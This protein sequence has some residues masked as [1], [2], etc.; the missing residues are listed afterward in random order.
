MEVCDTIGLETISKRQWF[1]IQK[2]IVSGDS[3]YD[4]PGH[5]ASYGTYSLLDIKLNLK[6]SY[7]LEVEGLERSLSHL[8]EYD[9]T[10]SKAMRLEY[11]S[12]QHE[13]DLWHIVKSGGVTK[14]KEKWISVLHHITNVH[15]CI[16]GETMAK[17]QHPTYTPEEES[18]CPWLLPNCA[19][20]QHLQK[21]VLG[22]QLLKKLEKTTLG[23]HTG[24]LESLHS[25]YTKYAT[26]RKKFLKEGFEARLWVAALDHNGNMNG[27]TAKTK[28]GEEQHKH[29]YSKAAQQ[30][31]V[32]PLKVEK[33]YTFRKNI[34]AGVISRLKLTSIQPPPLSSC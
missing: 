8:E 16:S 28:G 1:D 14:L 18:L 19:G 12:I 34:V 21:I 23:I 10:I 4:S 9:V 17:C 26:K 24:Q 13:Y 25:L 7:W 3:R 31:V 27:K 2:L 11:K 20:F 29:Q 30:Y 5:N 32:T 15:Y 22:K 33:D 6:N